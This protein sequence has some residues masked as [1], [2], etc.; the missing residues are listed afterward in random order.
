MADKT[1]AETIAEG[2]LGSVGV[3]VEKALSDLQFDKTYQPCEIIQ[4]AEDEA[5]K[6]VCSYENKRFKAYSDQSF[7]AGDMV[8]VLVP[9]NNWSNQKHIVGRVMSTGAA[10]YNFKYPFDDFLVVAQMDVEDL[11]SLLAGCSPILKNDFNSVPSDLAAWIKAQEGYVEGQD[12]VF[13][14]TPYSVDAVMEEMEAADIAAVGGYRKNLLIFTNTQQLIDYI[15]TDEGKEWYAIRYLQNL[16]GTYYWTTTEIQT[17]FK[18]ISTALAGDT[19]ETDFPV[20]I[21]GQLHKTTAMIGLSDAITK[22]NAYA[23]NVAADW[24]MDDSNRNYS[25]LSVTYDNEGNEIKSVVTRQGRIKLLNSLEATRTARKDAWLSLITK[26]IDWREIDRDIDF[27]EFKSRAIKNYNI[28]WDDMFTAWTEKKA[29]EFRGRTMNDIYNSYRIT[30]ICGGP[31]NIFKFQANRH[32]KDRL[33]ENHYNLPMIKLCSFIPAN[34]AKSIQGFT[35]AGLS[36]DI[37]TLLNSQR[38]IKGEYGVYIQIEGS[39]AT[40]GDTESTDV[41]TQEEYDVKYAELEAAM[42]AEIAEVSGD[43]S[44]NELEKQDRINEI[45]ERYNVQFTQLA[46]TIIVTDRQDSSDGTVTTVRFDDQFS[47]QTD[48][49][50]N[51]YAYTVPY[52]QQKLLNIENF[53][54][55]S[56]ISLYAYQTFDNPDPVKR[57]VA[58]VLQQISDKRA[59]IA[60]LEQIYTTCLNAAEGTPAR[61]NLSTASSQLAAARTALIKLQQEDYP[62]ALAS[63]EPDY[64]WMRDNPDPK[65]YYKRT[66]DGVNEEFTEYPPDDINPLFEDSLPEN[67]YFEKPYLGL[68]FSIDELKNGKLIL[69]TAD[70]LNYGTA[71]TRTNEEYDTRN[72]KLVWVQPENDVLNIYPTWKPGKDPNGVQQDKVELQPWEYDLFYRY[73]QAETFEKLKELY[74]TR[75]DTPY[76]SA[77]AQKQKQVIEN[78]QKWIVILRNALD[79]AKAYYLRQ[80][81]AQEITLEQWQVFKEELQAMDKALERQATD[82]ETIAETS[83]LKDDVGKTERL[84][85]LYRVK[86]AQLKHQQ[87]DKEQGAAIKQAMDQIMIELSKQPIETLI[88]YT[89]SKFYT[90]GGGGRDCQEIVMSVDGQGAVLYQAYTDAYNQLVANEKYRL[91]LENATL[92]TETD[93]SQQSE[94]LMEELK[95]GAMHAEATRL[96]TRIGDVHNAAEACVVLTMR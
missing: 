5:N 28:N 40:T 75:Y 53:V 93:Y 24:D 52:T 73:E 54:S 19:N 15:T 9:Q 89:P 10:A 12:Y 84:V 7:F 37:T 3:I 62:A 79:N 85:D 91:A 47:S 42:T 67:I 60:Q 17:V 55:I 78:I 58:P 6:Y 83:L 86:R 29:D 76:D 45:R 25:F 14:H 20:G 81:N 96:D 68:G 49:Y 23:E 8:Q 69:Y 1:L 41:I 72:L 74:I 44:L 32:F 30:Q 65:V 38:I 22:L 13:G 87:S 56:R 82:I 71:G 57:A 21:D 92:N 48:F 36:L 18:K 46:K 61:A 95:S 50:G 31:D 64:G 51:V 88:G 90:M 39:R 33:N 77:R 94:I 34:G 63:A 80:H 66:K 11:Y 43:N 70:D 2:V 16:D 59:E 27:E 4:R 35:R 26:N